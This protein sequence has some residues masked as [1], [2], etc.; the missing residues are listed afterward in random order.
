MYLR[1]LAALALSVS[2]TTVSHA[3]GP[4]HKHPWHKIGKSIS[5]LKK[6]Y[7]KQHLGG[8]TETVTC[9][10][11]NNTSVSYKTFLNDGRVLA[12]TVTVRIAGKTTQYL[13]LLMTNY[14][15]TDST[16]T[17]SMNA[18]TPSQSAFSLD[19]ALTH[20]P[21][22]QPNL[23][24]TYSG[25]VTV[26]A[27]SAAITC[28]VSRPGAGQLGAYT[29]PATGNFSVYCMRAGE[30]PNSTALP[31]VSFG[32]ARNHSRRLVSDFQESRA[33]VDSEAL[34]AFLV[35]Q[36][37]FGKQSLLAELDDGSAAGNMIVRLAA[38]GMR[39]PTSQPSADPAIFGMWS[40]TYTRFDA[41]RQLNEKVECYAF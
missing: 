4:H 15:N 18:A 34:P 12:S 23:V 10:G 21:T 25:S 19:L 29:Y 5:L 37:A 22:P 36:F 41:G 28:N 14:L 17:M 2:F 20:T 31:L 13:P 38:D 11:T 7:K 3:G 32:V 35:S 40:G 39:V 26:G 9:T 33:T 1:L 6:S 27:N 24:A 30:A 16:V 8:G